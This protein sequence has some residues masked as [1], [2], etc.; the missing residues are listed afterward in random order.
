M[1]NISR[2]F[3]AS[4]SN[5]VEEKHQKPSA[6]WGCLRIVFICFYPQIH[7]L[8]FNIL[9]QTEFIAG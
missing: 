5:S 8:Y 1:Y 7:W 3:Q 6:V 9:R 4:K 2:L